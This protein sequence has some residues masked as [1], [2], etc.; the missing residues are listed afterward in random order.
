MSSGVSAVSVGS[1]HACAI[2]FGA[3]K[4]WGG[5]AF[6]QLGDNSLSNRLSPVNVSGLPQTQASVSAG[7]RH[8]CALSQTG[9]VTCWGGNSSGQLGNGSTTNSG[10]PVNASGLSSGVSDIRVGYSHSCALL[11]TGGVHCWGANTFGQLGDGTNTVRNTPF[12]VSNLSVGAI[13]LAAGANSMCA[14]RSSGAI[15]CW[16]QNNY[17]SVGDGTFVHR[18][19]PTPVLNLQSGVSAI[20]SGASHVCASLVGGESQCWGINTTSQLADNS[21]TIIP[22]F[23]REF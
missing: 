11:S 18:N 8:S 14:L 9:Q 15:V 7:D 21:T 16:G 13:G 12:P 10:V 6:G 5:N 22:Q 23:V 19:L 20:G 1:E 2:V 4:C 17:G 3:A